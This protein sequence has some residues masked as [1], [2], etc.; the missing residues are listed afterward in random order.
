LRYQTIT[1]YILEYFGATHTD[2]SKPEGKRP[3]GINRRI[4]EDDIKMDI[5]EIRCDLAWINLA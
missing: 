5:K 3:L 1:K 2:I 4:W